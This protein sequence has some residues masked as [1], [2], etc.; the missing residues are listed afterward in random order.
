MKSII[1]YG[2]SGHG[3]VIADIIEK[4]GG[5][6]MGFVDDN[7][8]KWGKLYSGYRVLGGEEQLTKLCEAGDGKVAV[9]I[10]VGDNPTRE[11]IQERLAKKKIPF[12]MAVHPSAQIAKGV[13][14]GAGTVIMAHCAVNPDT[15]IGTHCIINTGAAIDHDGV[16]GDFVHISPGASLGGGVKVGDLTWIGLGASVINNIQV[17]ENSI[18]GAGAVVIRDVPSHSIVVGNPAKFLRK[19]QVGG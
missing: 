17:A 3:K 16:I 19:N 14:I 18:V 7:E 6:I 2:A 15:R 8:S 10:G 4:S 12:G 9:I 1:I 5:E 13:T 11:K